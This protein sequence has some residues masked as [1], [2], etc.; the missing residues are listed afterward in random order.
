MSNSSLP[1]EC[2]ASCEDNPACATGTC[3]C[4]HCGE[5]AVDEQDQAVPAPRATVVDPPVANVWTRTPE[6]DMNM[7][8]LQEYVDCIRVEDAH[9]LFGRPTSR[10]AYE[11]Q[12]AGYD[13]HDW[14]FSRADGRVARLYSR[15]GQLRI[16]AH[17][18]EAAF[19]FHAW[20]RSLTPSFVPLDK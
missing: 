20:L 5:A 13:G 6:A 10:E 17:S 19:E 9:V 8:S 2:M 18:P 3:G 12:E 15:W 7:S 1:T 11:D 4:A 14:V 16:G